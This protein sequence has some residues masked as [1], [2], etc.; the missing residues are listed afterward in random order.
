M[1]DI[2]KFVLKTSM[3]DTL[4]F[5]FLH[6]PKLDVY[7]TNTKVWFKLFYIL[8]N[9]DFKICFCLNNKW[10]A[11]KSPCLHPSLNNLDT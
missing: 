8:P 3:F 9:S 11:N 4:V 2:A 5:F 10:E 7:N 1:W 6:F